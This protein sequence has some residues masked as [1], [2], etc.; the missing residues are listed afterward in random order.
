LLHVCHNEGLVTG[1]ANLG[2]RC[3]PLRRA[4]SV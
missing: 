2:A 4:R 1:V 3:H